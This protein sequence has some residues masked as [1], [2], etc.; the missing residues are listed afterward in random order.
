MSWLYLLDDIV[1]GVVR[2]MQGA[3][4]RKKGE[5]VLPVPRYA[6]YNIG[7][8]QPESLLEFV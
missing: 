2:V 1:E 8:G 3:P 6:V 4:E 7:G 5:D